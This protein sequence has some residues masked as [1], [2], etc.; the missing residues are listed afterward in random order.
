MADTTAPSRTVDAYLARLDALLH[1]LPRER[2]GEIVADIREHIDA[3]IGAEDAPVGEA[4]VRNVLERLGDPSEIAD[5]AR[6]R[7][8]V[9]KRRPLTWQDWSVPV[10]LPF[11]TFFFFVG[12]FV[13]VAFLWRS[14]A[15][16]RWEKVVATAF[17]PLGLALPF[18]AGAFFGAIGTTGSATTCVSEPGGGETC[19]A[20]FES[21]SMAS[22][23]WSA[24]DVLLLVVG[25]APIVV[26]IYL[27]VRLI[28]VDRARSRG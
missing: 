26:A 5:D 16:R 6:Q 3:A 24:A 8:G 23:E 9:P 17:W 10:L 22:L 19:T 25:L 12:W 27:T 21:T 11:G 13:G 20:E 18:Y 14:R 15:F 7:F 2:R 28:L 1:D 4:A